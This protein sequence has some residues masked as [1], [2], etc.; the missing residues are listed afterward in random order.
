[1]ATGPAGAVTLSEGVLMAL[2]RRTTIAGLTLG[3]VAGS[4]TGL[5]PALAAHTNV[6]DVRVTP[7]HKV[8]L[9]D[10]IA[11]GVTKFVIDAPQRS[12]FQLVRPAAGYTR[13][14]AT[15]DVR[16]GLEQG[17]LPALRRFERNVTLLGGV[18]SRSEQS[19]RVW[20]DLTPGKYWALDTEAD[21][22]ARLL[23]KF[24]V[25]GTPSSALV[26][27][28]ST[29]RAVEEHRWAGTPKSIP[30]RGRLTFRN[31]DSDNHFVIMVKLRRGQRMDD[32]RRWIRQIQRGNETRP[33][34]DFRH[35][36][37]SG[38]LS[39][40]EEMTM[41]YRQPEGRYA[42][43]CFWPDADDD[44]MPH[45]FMGMLRGIRLT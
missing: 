38:V 7:G 3:L 6:V 5:S 25:R 42:L 44:G 27:E 12:S 15:R 29:I 19:G 35:E 21:L 23:N 2:P 37:D 45:A 4:M 13:I 22:R 34:F 26:P 20:V 17:R 43:L 8:I 18:T 9:P 10:E 1:M 14:E 11:P 16:R 39:P 30:H 40:G 24:R 28:A 36:A 41:A 33:P 31:D 32:V